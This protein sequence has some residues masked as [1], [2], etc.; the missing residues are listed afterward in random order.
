MLS[1]QHYVKVHLTL[2]LKSP[3][4]FSTFTVQVYCQQQFAQVVS[5]TT[6]WWQSATDSRKELSTRLFKTNGALIGAN[7]ALLE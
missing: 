4:I 1:K 7:K 5:L 2:V 3:Q 6:Q